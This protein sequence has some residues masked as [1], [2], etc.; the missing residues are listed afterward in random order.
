M[1][2]MTLQDLIEANGDDEGLELGRPQKAFEDP[3]TLKTAF[4]IEI[5]DQ[6]VTT[7]KNGYTQLELSVGIITASG[8]VKP[9]GR[10]W[11]MLP[12]FSDEIKAT[13]D[14]EKLIA[15]KETFGKTLH[16]VL[17]AADEATFSVFAKADKNGKKWTFFDFDGNVIPADVKKQREADLGKA[18]LGTASLIEQGKYSLV[19]KRMYLVRNPAK[20][21]PQKVYDNYYSDV[22]TSYPLAEV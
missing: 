12:K 4:P 13:Q 8:D 14:P 3:F 17:R 11:V 22:P 20:N 21:N 10:R 16:G 5:T 1:S 6:K 2:T 19:G 7:T 9:A 15:L 18:I